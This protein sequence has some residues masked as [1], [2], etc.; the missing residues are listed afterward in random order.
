MLY[1]PKKTVDLILSINCDFLIQLKRNC[2]KLLSNITLYC[3]LTN[4]KSVYEYYEKDHGNEIYRCVELYDVPDDVIPEGWNGIKRIIKVRR[5][6]YRRQKRFEETAFFMHS[7][8]DTKVHVLANAIQG[9]WSIE[10]QLHWTKDVIMGE[11][12][13]SLKTKNA[14]VSIAF[15]NNVALN[16]IRAAGEKPIKDTF[17]KYSNNIGRLNKLLHEKFA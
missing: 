1:T 8:A 7:N 3:A 5:W 14:M 6:G 2:R 4:P 9:H 16:I 10:N 17:A 13:M 15:L 11:D 12:A